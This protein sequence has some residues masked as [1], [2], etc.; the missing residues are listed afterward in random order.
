MCEANKINNTT[1]SVKF[2][3]FKL[4]S[5]GMIPVIV[6][7]YITNEVLMMAYMNE[8]AYNHKTII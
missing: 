6:Q 1:V 4:N 8:E 7:D 3:E 5:D 2:E